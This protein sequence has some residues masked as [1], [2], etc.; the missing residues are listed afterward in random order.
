MKST[1]FQSVTDQVTELLRKGMREGRWRGTL[2]GRYQLAEELG[3]NHKTV[4]TA[5]QRLIKEGMLV[6]QRPPL[7]RRIVLP[8]GD[9][10]KRLNLRVRLLPYESTSRATG[11]WLKLLDQLKL[12]G[13]AADFARKTL[14]D[15]RMQ[16]DRVA[17]FVAKIPADAWIVES[18]SHEVLAWFAKQSVPIL[19]ISGRFSGLPI[20]AISPRFAPAVVQATQRLF[21]LGHRRIVMLVREERRSP[22]PAIVEQAFLDALDSLGIKTGGYNLPNWKNDAA[23][24]RDC[25]KGLFRYSAPTALILGDNNFVAP[26]QQFLGRMGIHAPEQVSLI[27]PSRETAFDWCDPALSHFHW[28]PEQSVR[29]ARKWVM[30]LAEGREDKR[31]QLF[32]AE[33][34]EGG[35]IGPVPRHP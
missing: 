15:L 10:P 6:A 25:L 23:G 20:A 16:P 28:D 14:L 2:P 19:A 17:R 27:C 30:N 11:H 22:H 13:L 32:N 4:E 9:V 21:E 12:S 35:T 7:R 33:F 5:A 18:A 1:P 29:R 3:V 26:V 34:V 31:Q 24:L 8:E